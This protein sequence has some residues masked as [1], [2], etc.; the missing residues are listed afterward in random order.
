[1]LHGL[2]HFEWA[3]WATC[4]SQPI[5]SREHCK[6]CICLIPP[7]SGLSHITYYVYT[8]YMANFFLIAYMR[9]ENYTFLNA[10]QERGCFFVPCSS[11][12]ESHVEKLLIEIDGEIFKNLTSIFLSS[13]SET[14]AVRIQQAKLCY[15][16][17]FKK[18]KLSSPLWV[19]FNSCQNSAPFCSKDQ[20]LGSHWSSGLRNCDS[21]TVSSSYKLQWCGKTALPEF[22]EKG[23]RCCDRGANTYN[24][25]VLSSWNLWVVFAGTQPL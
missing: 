1:M 21:N 11:K 13:N 6:I 15:F 19:L 7:P 5:N 18:N 9:I 14:V 25:Q 2:I 17:W 16:N 12:K 22:F 4:F 3:T 23:Y 8:H 24:S 20:V 10:I